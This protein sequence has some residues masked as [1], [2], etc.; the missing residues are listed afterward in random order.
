M[1]GLIKQ[2]EEIELETNGLSVV[3]NLRWVKIGRDVNQVITILPTCVANSIEWGIGQGLQPDPAQTEAAPF[4][5]RPGHRKNL[6]PKLT[7]TI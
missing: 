6:W 2:V 1:L 7:A 3:G 5:H 4:T